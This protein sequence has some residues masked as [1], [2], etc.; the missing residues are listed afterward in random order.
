MKRVNFPFPKNLEVF[1]NRKYQP[2]KYEG[3]YRVYSSSTDSN[4][5]YVREEY[6]RITPYDYLIFNGIKPRDRVSG[7]L[8][9]AGASLIFILIDEKAPNR[10]GYFRVSAHKNPQ[11]GTIYEGISLGVMSRGWYSH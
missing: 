2:C 7:K 4:E 8:I 11:E 3:T 10:R 1:N 6:L 9:E 5:E